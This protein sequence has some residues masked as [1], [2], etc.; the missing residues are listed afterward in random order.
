MDGL[1]DAQILSHHTDTPG[2]QSRKPYPM[3]IGD[4]DDGAHTRIAPGGIDYDMGVMQ[5]PWPVLWA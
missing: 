1:F 5:P 4:G 2:C 3:F